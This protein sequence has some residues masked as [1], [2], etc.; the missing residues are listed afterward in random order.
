V[1]LHVPGI[2]VGGFLA[3]VCFLL[4]FW[5]HYLPGSPFWLEITLFL[6]G[7]ACLLVE[8]FVLPGLVIFGLGGGAM[9]LISLVLASQ[10]FVLPRN[11]YQVEKLEHTLLSIAGAGV[12]LIAACAV[13]R[14]WL[15]RAPAYRHMVLEPPAGEEA[16]TIS[17]HETRADLESLLGS[18]GVTTT[19]LSPAG[20]AR[21]GNTLVDVISGGDFI[22]RNTPVTVAEVHGNRVLVRPVD[23]G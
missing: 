18:Q 11:E 6:A 22:P 7:I 5:G 9:V 20:K 16:R 14:R 21:F 13:L 10:T 4:F 19:Q 15:P 2:G 12:G 3:A 8:V 23:N 17:R 1:E